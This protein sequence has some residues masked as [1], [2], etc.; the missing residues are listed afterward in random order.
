VPYHEVL[1]ILN[2]HAMLVV[3]SFVAT[4]VICMLL[5]MIKGTKYIPFLLMLLWTASIAAQTVCSTPGI[6]IDKTFTVT[7][8]TVEYGANINGLG[9]NQKLNMDIYAPNNDPSISRP[10]MILAFGGSFIFGTRA[11]MEATAR[12]FATRGY[13]AASIDYRLHS[14]LQGLPDSTQY[15]AIVARAMQDMKASIRWFRK[16]AASTNTYKIDTNKIFSGGLSAGAITAILAATIDETDPIPATIRTQINNLGGFEGNSGNSGYSSSV[17][18]VLNFSGGIYSLDWLDKSDPPISSMQGDADATVPYNFGLAL[19]IVPINGSGRIHPRLN[20]IGIPNMLVTVPGGG[21]TDIYTAA[22]FQASRDEFTS[23]GYPFFKNIICNT[24][25]STEEVFSTRKM[26]LFP[27]PSTGEFTIKFEED[28][29]GEIQILD[30]AGAIKN[31]IQVSTTK[32][33]PI[34][35]SLS[36]GMYIL[37]GKGVDGKNYLGRVVINQ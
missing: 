27:N 7:K 29:T 20:N 2:E 17:A 21:H 28:F 25:V 3:G 35:S 30:L 37:K 23:K 19:G 18:G 8:T 36:A 24:N 26:E 6:Y 31:T 16:N 4:F 1:L 32:F 9:Q 22:Q 13:V 5:K 34:S 14:I 11:D 33:F 12:E 10:V 15:F